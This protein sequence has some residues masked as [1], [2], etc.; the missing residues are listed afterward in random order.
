MIWHPNLVFW[1]RGESSLTDSKAGLVGTTRGTGAV[2]YDTG[3]FGA[4]IKFNGTNWFNYASS[5]TTLDFTQKTGIGTIS[6]FRKSA[7]QTASYGGYTFSTT[8]DGGTYGFW[9]CQYPGAYLMMFILQGAGT[10]LI[11]N[12]VT[13]DNNVWTHCAWSFNKAADVC[14]GYKNGIAYNSGSMSAWST[15]ANT[16][17]YELTSGNNPDQNNYERVVNNSMIDDIRVYNIALPA[18]D[19]IRL[20]RGFDPLTR[21]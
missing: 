20:S 4:G 1:L 14:V 17:Q 8:K 16:S 19:I 11:Y 3:I 13:I 2:A 15:T 12:E 10:R 5:K 6:F 7:V 21:S 9:I 18:S